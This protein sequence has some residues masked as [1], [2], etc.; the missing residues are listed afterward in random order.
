MVIM[1][2]FD[3]PQHLVDFVLELSE[4]RTCKGCKYEINGD[5]KLCSCFC[6][7]SPYRPYYEPV[8]QQEAT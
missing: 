3:L 4:E 8:L 6:V 1:F 7:N 2:Q 5:C